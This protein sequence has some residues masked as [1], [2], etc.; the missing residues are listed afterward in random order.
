MVE[1][2]EKQGRLIPGQSVVIEPTSGNTG[3]H[4]DLESESRCTDLLNLGVGL[5]LACAIKGYRCIIVMPEKMSQEK[6]TTIAAL[7]SH[8][9][10][11]LRTLKHEVGRRDR[12]HADR[13]SI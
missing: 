11:A 3:A 6:A 2:A 12:S 7:V 4:F 8:L 13:S 10:T 5:A 9:V 1:E